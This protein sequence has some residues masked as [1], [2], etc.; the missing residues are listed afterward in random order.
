M[1]TLISKMNDISIVE[2][3]DEQ[4]DEDVD[5]DEKKDEVSFV[6][7]RPPT[8]PKP[9]TCAGQ[10]LTCTKPCQFALRKEDGTRGCCY[11]NECGFAHGWDEFKYI[12][13]KFPNCY[14]KKV[15]PFKHTDETGKAY[16]RRINKPVPDL[17]EKSDETRKKRI[18]QQ[19]EPE[20]KM[21][22]GTPEFQKILDATHQ[23]VINMTNEVAK[24]M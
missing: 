17:P 24:Q 6:L 1:D 23:D 11:K 5:E 12:E 2:D 16:F 19:Y 21:C 7:D 4:V 15:C 18:P 8:P 9:K 3:V 10:A 14:R 22:Y 13:C 20:Q